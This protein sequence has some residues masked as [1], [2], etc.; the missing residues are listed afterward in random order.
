MPLQGV[1][2]M[3]TPLELLETPH[4]YGSFF[5]TSIAGPTSSVE[6]VHHHDPNEKLQSSQRQI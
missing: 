6:K 4:M 3:K 2:S 1:V 5:V